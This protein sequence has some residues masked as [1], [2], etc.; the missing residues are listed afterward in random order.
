MLLFT[1]ERA[2]SNKRGL[3]EFKFNEEECMKNSIL[4]LDVPMIP[5]S[6]N[7]FTTQLLRSFGITRV[8]T[9]WLLRKYRRKE[10][11]VDNSEKSCGYDKFRPEMGSNMHGAARKT[12]REFRST[13]LIFFFFFFLFGYND[14]KRLHSNELMYILLAERILFTRYKSTLCDLFMYM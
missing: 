13:S 6:C 1:E 14:L 3:E 7:L 12:R 11:R 4:K 10:G 8:G 9:G 5:E 2:P